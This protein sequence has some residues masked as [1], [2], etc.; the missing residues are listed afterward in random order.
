MALR[1]R[2]PGLCRQ[3]TRRSAPHA[4]ATEAANPLHRPIQ[5][6]S[7]LHNSAVGRKYLKLQRIGADFRSFRLPI[8]S[9]NT[10]AGESFHLDLQCAHSRRKRQDRKSTRL[11]S[12]HTVISYAV[13]C[14]KKKKK[15][16]NIETTC[17]C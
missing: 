7:L 3:K 8:F 11:N 17:Y 13:L 15:S 16:N 1:Q 12:S 4:A 14:L 6:P 10:L 2:R 5:R 9:A